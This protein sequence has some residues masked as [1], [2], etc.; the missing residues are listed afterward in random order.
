MRDGRLEPL[1]S[2]PALCARRRAAVHGDGTL[3]R[4]PLR[5]DR[6]RVVPRIR[7]LLERRVVLLVDD[8]EAELAH[9]REDRRSSTDDDPRLP[10]RDPRALVASFRVARAPSGAPPPVAESC[11]N[12]PTRLRRQRDLRDEHDRRRARARARRRSLEV[13]LGLPASRRPDGAGRGLRPSSS[14]ADDPRDGSLAARPSARPVRL[15]ERLALAGDGARQAE[16]AA[17]R[18]ATSASARAGVDP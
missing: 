11:R 1:E 18:G 16:H 3:D 6:P 17:M 8:D 2:R 14:A 4:R 15:A 13:D 7:L 9:R 12:R 5:G 10:G